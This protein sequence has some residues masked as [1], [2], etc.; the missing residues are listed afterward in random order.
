MTPLDPGERREDGE[1]GEAPAD[2]VD[3]DLLTAFEKLVDDR[4]E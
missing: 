4:A 2:A 3:D 1:E